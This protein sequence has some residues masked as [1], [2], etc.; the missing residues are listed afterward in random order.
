MYRYSVDNAVTYTPDDL[1]LFREAPFALW[2][3]RLTLE[4]PEHG[5]P[6]DLDSSAPESGA[7]PQDDIVDTL[8]DEGEE[9]LPDACR[10]ISVPTLLVR[11]ANSELVTE[12]AAAE[13][14]ELVPH[15]KFVDVSDA[16]H[17][18]AGDRN[19][20]FNGAVLDFL[21]ESLG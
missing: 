16:G 1:V 9:R 6:P 13:F 12:E 21:R 20:A 19:D 17:M 5:I 8:R 18:V 15:S 10:S 14:L 2:M 3:E 4:N 7:R 11:G